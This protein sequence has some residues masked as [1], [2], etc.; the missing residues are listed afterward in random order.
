MATYTIQDTTLTNI[1]DAIRTKGNTT[2]TLTPVEMPDA[3][4]AIQTGGGDSK[5]SR[6]GA[7][8]PTASTVSPKLLSTY[9]DTSTFV[10]LYHFPDLDTNTSSE[11]TRCWY[12]KTKN[13]VWPVFHI[14]PASMTEGVTYRVMFYIWCNPGKT[15]EWSSNNVYFNGNCSTTHDLG[16]ITDKPQF[17]EWDFTYTKSSSSYEPTLHIYPAYTNADSDTYIMMSPALVY[18]TDMSSSY[19]SKYWSAYQEDIEL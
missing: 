13:D 19:Y 5:P 14:K 11:S 16:P 12:K 10:Y 3:I 2:E 17:F 18:R 8:L 7:Y 9:S 6:K 15:V 4:N 1:A